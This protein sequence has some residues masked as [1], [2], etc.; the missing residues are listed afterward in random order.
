MYAEENMPFTFPGYAKEVFY[1]KIDLFKIVFDG[2]FQI[3]YWSSFG[4]K[5]ALSGTEREQLLADAINIGSAG[6]FP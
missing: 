2:V 6:V 4:R 3:T 5:S 1:G